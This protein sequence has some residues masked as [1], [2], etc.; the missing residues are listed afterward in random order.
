MIEETIN[1]CEEV[2]LRCQRRDSNS[3]IL[4]DIV[5]MITKLLHVLFFIREL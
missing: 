1:K 2:G 4:K 3:I 5:R